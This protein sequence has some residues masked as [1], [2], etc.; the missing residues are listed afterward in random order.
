M[1]NINGFRASLTNG[2]VRPNQFRVDLN[3][4]AN[5]V[6][7]GATAA[8]L[9]R[10]H[11]KSAQVPSSAVSPIPVF[12][13]GRQINVAGEREFQ[14]WTVSVYNENFMIRDALVRWS[15][16]FNNIADNSGE[17]RPAFYQ[18]DISFVQLDRNGRELKQWKLV[19]C[20]PVDVGGIE[21]DWEA[22]NQVEIFPVTFVYNWFEESQITGGASVQINATVSF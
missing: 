5:L 19:D 11:V 1:A 3:F 12:Y 16:G 14:P 7:G 15:N 8:S 22:N 9:G 21:L 2:L 4:P 10:F 18:T 20:M 13:M 17:I 6:P